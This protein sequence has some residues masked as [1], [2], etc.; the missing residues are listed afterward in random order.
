MKTEWE[1]IIHIVKILTLSLISILFVRVIFI[2]ISAVSRTS[3]EPTLKDHDVLIIEKI[4][5]LL[6][7]YRRGD[8]VQAFNPQ[9]KNLIVK[10]VAGL[11]GETVYYLDGQVAVKNT[12][13]QVFVL[14]N[15]IQTELIPRFNAQVLG[16][17]QYFLLGDNR[18]ISIDSRVFGPVHRE[19]II[20][21]AWYVWSN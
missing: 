19:D 11:P 13:G 20:G 1:Y 4:S 17:N 6:T 10:R 7:P 3:M 16:Q 8:I 2:D 18:H 14:Q 9:D 21:R 15:M 12:K 5:N